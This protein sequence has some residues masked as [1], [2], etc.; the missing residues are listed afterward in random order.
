MQII[1][2][3]LL[4]FGIAFCGLGTLGLLRMP[5]VYTRLHAAGKISTV[6][7]ASIA[8]GAAILMPA[9]TL[10]VLALVLFMI[11]MLPISSQ[12]MALAAYRR[13]IPM[14][15]PVRDD[16]ANAQCNLNVLQK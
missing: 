12:A 9:L 8:L 2:V 6:G 4:W 14:K 10:K 15:N 13:G 11:M 1:G 3:L 16:L 5:D 7:L